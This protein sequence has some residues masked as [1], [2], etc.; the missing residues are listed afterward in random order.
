MTLKGLEAYRPSYMLLPN[1]NFF[2]DGQIQ[3]GTILPAI[4]G[5]QLPDPG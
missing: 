2:P 5:G 4:K 1:F 3:L